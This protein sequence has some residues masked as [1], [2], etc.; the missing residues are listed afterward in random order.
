MDLVRFVMLLVLFGGMEISWFVVKTFVGVF[1]RRSSR[2]GS[3][4]NVLFEP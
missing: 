4:A 1:W 3:L 2:A